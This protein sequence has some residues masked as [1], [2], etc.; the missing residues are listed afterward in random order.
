M[1][2]TGYKHFRHHNVANERTGKIEEVNNNVRVVDVQDKELLIYDDVTRLWCNGNLEDMGE[3]STGE[4][5]MTFSCA[6]WATP[7]YNVTTK[8]YKNGNQ[9]TLVVPE[10][11]HA[12]TPGLTTGHIFVAAMPAALNPQK[13]APCW[14]IKCINQATDINGCVLVA[15]SMRIFNGGVGQPFSSIGGAVCGFRTFAITYIVASAL[16]LPSEPADPVVDPVV[17]VAAPYTTA[18]SLIR[19][20]TAKTSLEEVD[21]QVTLPA[22][23]QFKLTSGTTDLTVTADCIINQNL[24]T[25]STPTFASLTLGATTTVSSILDEDAMTT[26]SATALATQQSIKAYVDSKV[27]GAVATSVDERMA[28]YDGTNGIQGSGITISDADAISG[29]ASINLIAVSTD[30]RLPRY[31]GSYG[32]QGSGIT[33]SD[34]DDLSGVNEMKSNTIATDVITQKTAGS[35]VTVA[36]VLMKT[37]AL[38]MEAQAT[39]PIA[40]ADT[41]VWSYTGNILRVGANNVMQIA[42]TA[43]TNHTIPRFNGTSSHLLESS[44]VIISDTNAITGAASIT[45]TN[46]IDEFSTDG[47]LAGNSD[48]ALPTEKAVKT[49]VDGTWLSHNVTWKGAISDTASTLAYRIAN[50]CAIIDF[51]AFTGTGASSASTIHNTGTELPSAIRPAA[52]HNEMMYCQDNGNH[53][54]AYVLVRTTGIISIYRVQ[55]SGSNVV[56]ANFSSNAGNNGLLHNHT[57]KYKLT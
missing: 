27:G 11:I 32:L 22:A 55:V 18:D 53:M 17:V 47:T 20:N 39:N 35:G 51:P 8:W 7:S 21:C 48:T 33:V 6:C 14:P 23:N 30:K 2:T 34:T 43:V 28:R 37:M 5:V 38:S 1:S 24:S 10:Q 9:V 29:A 57:M 25:T 54:Q 50:G 40:S 4:E 46:A 49:Y 31:S 56:Y 41:D 3:Y 36:G 44:G 52:D 26:N 13:L 15:S 45:L 12:T 19:V 42:T 16:V